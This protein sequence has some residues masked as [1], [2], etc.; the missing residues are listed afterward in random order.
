MN[1]DDFI[2]HGMRRKIGL[3]NREVEEEKADRK[4]L[5]EERKKMIDKAGGC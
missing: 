1:I 2:I 3:H 5:E 4:R